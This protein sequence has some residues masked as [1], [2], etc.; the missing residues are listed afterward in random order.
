MGNHVPAPPPHSRTEP[1]F[2]FIDTPAPP[3]TYFRAPVCLCT[4]CCGLGYSRVSPPAPAQALSPR[5]FQPL[6]VNLIFGLR[7]AS[8]PQACG[9]GRNMKPWRVSLYQIE[10]EFTTRRL[11]LIRVIV[12]RV[13]CVIRGQMQYYVR[14]TVIQSTM[15]SHLWNVSDVDE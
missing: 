3:I 6:P 5:I 13:C 4:G 9:R 15:G 8:A 14:S 10:A 11:E 12:D 7:D 2:K 1:T